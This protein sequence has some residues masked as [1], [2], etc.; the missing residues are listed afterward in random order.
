MS[1]TAQSYSITL[2]ALALCYR[3]SS[4]G[5][6]NI[7]SP[8]LMLKSNAALLNDARL[9]PHSQSTQ[10]YRQK[11]IQIVPTVNFH[12]VSCILFW[13]C[14][15]FASRSTLASSSISRGFRQAKQLV[16][17][18]VLTGPETGCC[19]AMLSVRCAGMNEEGPSRGRCVKMPTFIAS[20]R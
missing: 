18:L 14:F 5:A 4:V 6:I 15:L 1:E 2:T 16:P 3:S 7:I 9:S 19:W 17:F 20:Y 8:T 10:S 12:P 13:F 11:K